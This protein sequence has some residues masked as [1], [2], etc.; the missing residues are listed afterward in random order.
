M[1]RLNSIDGFDTKMY[2][3]ANSIVRH[4][5]VIPNEYG[6]N[7][8]PEKYFSPE[9][10][11]S[12]IQVYHT[13]IHSEGMCSTRSLTKKAKIS[14]SSAKKTIESFLNESSIPT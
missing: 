10:W 7:Y 4:D 12:I 9:R 6:V 5:M 13:T 1:S 8:S 14:R 2:M 11:I 3:H